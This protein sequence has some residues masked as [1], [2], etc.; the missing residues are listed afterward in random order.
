MKTENC[1]EIK[2]KEENVI[3]KYFLNKCSNLRMG[4]DILWMRVKKGMIKGIPDFYRF[5]VLDAWRDFFTTH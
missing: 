3:M 2:M 4:D 1:K 5:K